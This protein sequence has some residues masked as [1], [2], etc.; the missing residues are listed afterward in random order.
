MGCDDPPSGDDPMGCKDIMGYGDPIGCG[1]PMG[2]NDPPAL[3]RPPWA[4]TMFGLCPN[5]WHFITG[6]GFIRR[7]IRRPR[8]PRV[9]C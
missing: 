1:G 2:Y 4:A 3:R 7:N 5:F 9:R 8:R 6:M